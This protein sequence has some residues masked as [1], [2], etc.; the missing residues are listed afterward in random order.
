VFNGALGEMRG[1]FGIH[2]A[3]LAAQYGLD[4]EDD[5]ASILPG[6]S[7]IDDPDESAVGRL[8]FPRF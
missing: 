7:E 6:P 1:V 8:R 2:I 3:K 5:L 4:V